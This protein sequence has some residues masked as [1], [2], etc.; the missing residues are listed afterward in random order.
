MVVF[1]EHPLMGCI[2]SHGHIAGDGYF[3]VCHGLSKCSDQTTGQN[4]IRYSSHCQLRHPRMGKDFAYLSAA[5]STVG[6]DVDSSID[7]IAAADPGVSHWVII[8]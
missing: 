4:Q 6:P 1:C 8:V 3:F 7:P 5:D 2:C